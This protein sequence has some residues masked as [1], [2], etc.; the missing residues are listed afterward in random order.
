VCRVLAE[1]IYSR[2]IV[3]ACRAG[4]VV[5]VIPEERQLELRVH[6]RG[7][8]ALRV[9]TAIGLRRDQTQ[10]Q[11]ARLWVKRLKGSLS[12]EHPI[13]GE[14]LRAIKKYL[15]TRASR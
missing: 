7:P 5:I 12:V 10:P 14:E 8:N 13:D 1:V 4:Q 3:M 15:A 6:G 11:R 9:S 2:V